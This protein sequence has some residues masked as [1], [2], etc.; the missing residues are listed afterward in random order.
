MILLTHAVFAADDE[1]AVGVY[2]ALQE[3]GLK[4]PVQVRVVGF[5]NQYFTPYLAPPLTTVNVPL[6]DM[7]RIAVQ[8]LFERIHTGAGDSLELMP[9]ELVIRQSC[10]CGIQT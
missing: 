2:Q 3:A 7:G 5:D 8:K 9:T 4:I 1:T 10:G 6:F